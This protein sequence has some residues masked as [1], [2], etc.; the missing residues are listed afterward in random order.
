MY[1]TEKKLSVMTGGLCAVDGVVANGIHTGFKA[2]DKDLALIYF[3]DGA[4]VTG[5]F[6]RN[7]VKAHSVL[8]D[9]E[10]LESFTDFKAIL[11]NSGNANACNGRNGEEDVEAMTAALSEKLNIEAHE[12]LVSSTGVIG[13]PLDLT[14]FYSGLDTLVGGLG[15]T[16]STAAAE[17]IMTTDTVPKE[18]SFETEIG[19][20]T[21]HFGAIIKGAGMIHPNMG[22]MLG[23]IVTDAGLPQDALNTA[24]KSAADDSFNVMT[25]DGDTSTNDT[26]LLAATNKVM[27]DESHIDE[28][29]HVLTEMCKQLSQMVARDAEGATKFVTVNVV[30]AASK[31]DAVSVAKTVATSSLVKTAVYGQDA[32]WGRVIMAVGNSGAETLDPNAIT[33][34]FTS[35]KDEVLVCHEGLAVPFDEALAFNI[36]G[37]TDVEIFIDLNSGEYSG[38]VWTCDMSVDYVK[39]NADYRS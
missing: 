21:I 26:V 17:A 35:G 15:T 9:M 38:E 31:S 16:G 3:P 22:T 18:L 2:Q 39:I 23:Y 11:V 27:L 28:F 12:V 7:K 36:L 25:V 34:K 1:I 24:L 6:T 29:T 37:C 4:T 8:Y 32:N 5:V 10:M 30:N 14:P 19:G 20:E 13:E 33:I